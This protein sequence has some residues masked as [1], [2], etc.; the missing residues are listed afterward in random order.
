M[1]ESLAGLR[2]DQALAR[3]VE[4]CSRSFLQALMRDGRVRINGVIAVQKV[5]VATGD[6][7]VVQL[8]AVTE[9]PGRAEPIDLAV[10]FEDEDVIVL[11]K[12]AGLVVHPG[13]GNR[14]GTLMNALLHHC[15][16]LFAL[17]RA[18]IVHRLDKD[19]SGIMVVAR[20]EN[21]RQ[22]LIDD[23]KARRVGREYRAICVGRLISG[24]RIDA[25][26]GRHPRNR[27]KMAVTG[28]GRPAVTHYRVIER[29]RAHTELRVTLETGRTHQIRVHMAHLGHPLLGDTLY[30]GQSRMPAGIGEKLRG[31]VSTFPRQALHAVKLT[32]NHPQ[33]GAPLTFEAPLPEDYLALLRILRED[34]DEKA[35]P[36]GAASRVEP[37]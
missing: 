15:R 12:P 25:P 2:L 27:L 1:P 14:D 21:A 32:F 37:P 6:E 10:L 34:R 11:D 13:A 7:V 17:P 23:L 3:M 5:R 18:G 8:P 31:A 35:A 24:G 9:E 30:G 26:I 4:N 16:D 22:V 28:G 19:T 36:E 29:F 33:S 20:N